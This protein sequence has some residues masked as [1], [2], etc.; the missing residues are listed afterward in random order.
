[1]NELLM[2]VP[3]PSSLSRLMWKSRLLNDGKCCVTQ[4]VKQRPE[5]GVGNSPAECLSL[6]PRKILSSGSECLACQVSVAL[7]LP[8]CPSGVPFRMCILLSPRRSFGREQCCFN[9]VSPLYC[10]SYVVAILINKIQHQY[11]FIDFRYDI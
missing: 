8:G 9:T 5:G 1:M 10:C 6:G 2:P 4:S 7:R 3:L 11:F